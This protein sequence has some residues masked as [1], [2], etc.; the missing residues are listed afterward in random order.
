[1]WVRPGHEIIAELGG[2]HRF[3]GW[4]G[5]ILTD[6][7]GYQVFSLKEHTRISEEGVRFRSPD[8]GAYRMLTPEVAVEVQES[9]GVDVAMAFDECIEWPATRERVARSTER[10]TR[11]LARC[12]AA[13]RHP[14]RTALFGIVQGGMFADLRIAHADELSAMDLDGYAIGG[15]SVG[16]ASLNQLGMA[17]ITAARLPRDRVRYLMGVGHPSDIV[18][19]VIRGVD[20]FDCVIPTRAGRHGQ[21]YT[22]HGR[23]NLRNG[24]YRRDPEP[25]DPSCACPTCTTVS[26][27]YLHH[28]VKT[29]EMLGKR[30]LTHHNL[31]FYQ[32]ILRDLRGAILGG[33]AERVACVRETALRATAP[34]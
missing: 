33:S 7:G 25:L 18:E 13:R 30:L 16:A 28:L 11:W 12:L 34:A 21:A 2:L 20:L 6:S 19:A 5:P 32:W 26:R 22:A 27:A 9:F 3:M 24:R 1:M 15:L 17:E 8:D 4:D 10:T 23:R 14:D 29:D 31:H